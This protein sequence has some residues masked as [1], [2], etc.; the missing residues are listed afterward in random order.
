MAIR[1]LLERDALCRAIVCYLVS[2]S[3]A[4]DTARGI[5]EWWVNSAVSGTADALLRLEALGVVCAYPVHDAT[6]VYAYTKN[7]LLRQSLRHY[8]DEAFRMAETR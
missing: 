3:E 2:H 6:T 8:V 1:A 5:A 7:P 4:A